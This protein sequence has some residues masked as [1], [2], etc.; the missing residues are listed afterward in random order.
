MGLF[1]GRASDW[2]RSLVWPARDWRR[3]HREG[4]GAAAAWRGGGAWGILARG[5]EG[6][7]VSPAAVEASEP[8]EGRRSLSV[9]CS[10]HVR[11]K[12]GKMSRASSSSSSSESTR[13]PNL[14]ATSVLSMMS[15]SSFRA[16]GMR[17]GIAAAGSPK[18]SP[19]RAKGKPSPSS[20][21]NTRRKASSTGRGRPGGREYDSRLLSD[22]SSSSPPA[23]GNSFSSSSSKNLWRM[24]SLT[25]GRG[26]G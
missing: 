13:T 1:V 21:K 25:G 3:N 23:T 9:L 14:S 17:A 5:V 7:V 8:T 6:W 22:E 24:C 26:A 4:G 2:R 10:M 15:P 20:S 19:C 16:G 11:R 18:W 12:A